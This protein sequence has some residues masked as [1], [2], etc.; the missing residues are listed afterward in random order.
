MSDRRSQ[1]TQ[2]FIAAAISTAAAAVIGLLSAALF[3][4]W[5]GLL[6]AGVLLLTITMLAHKALSGATPT[7]RIVRTACQVLLVGLTVTTAA[8]PFNEWIAVAAGT[9]LGEFG[10]SLT[11]L[12]PRTNNLPYF[13][14]F[15]VAI[16]ACVVAAV[17]GEAKSNAISPT[18]PA[19]EPADKNE[20]IASAD[21]IPENDRVPLG[22]PARGILVAAT[23][24]ILTIFIY[25]GVT[26]EGSSKQ[27]IGFVQT[28]L[29]ITTLI[30][31]INVWSAQRASNTAVRERATFW[32]APL[33][34]SL[35]LEAFI[36]SS[37][38]ISPLMGVLE[39]TESK[40]KWKIDL[41]LELLGI[42]TFI[43][44]PLGYLSWTVR[45]WRGCKSTDQYQAEERKAGV[46][47]VE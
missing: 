18:I 35:T 29:I 7:E 12:P 26:L 34:L 24:A 30:Y 11:A 31:C 42:A 41:N 40:I 45:S 13:A 4:V 33:F 25:F 23:V 3:G 2:T 21:A 9:M 15:A 43:L 14:T 37:T 20:L 1:M 16:T 19:G 17:R 46:C 22:L 27:I 6:F 44:G 5:V 28:S 32:A 8:P 38:G 39:L 47:V 36:M 10:I